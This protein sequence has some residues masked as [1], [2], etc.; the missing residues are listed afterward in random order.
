[1]RMLE[2]DF[3]SQSRSGAVPNN[4]E[5]LYSTALDYV[6][7]TYYGQVGPNFGPATDQARKQNPSQAYASTPTTLTEE[8]QQ[9]FRNVL[10]SRFP[11]WNA[12]VVDN[13]R[14]WTS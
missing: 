6:K 7:K 13:K 4:Q 5:R 1:M 8:E 9:E 2:M 3:V 12:G 10:S 14:L 11:N